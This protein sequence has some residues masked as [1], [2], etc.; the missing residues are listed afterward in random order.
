MTIQRA[1]LLLAQNG[2][3][4]ALAILFAGFA[5]ANP[6]F[7]SL[8]NVSNILGQSVELAL[9]A[10]P[11][12]LLVISGSID[13]SVG[14][15]A[16]LAAVSAALCM[17]AT[18]S[19]W[20]GLTAGL[21]VGAAA[22]L[23]NGVLVAY[24]GFNSFVV[25]L[26]FLSIWGGLALLLSGGRGI[27]GRDLPGEFAAL[28]SARIGPF[29]LTLLILVVAVALAWWV[30]D[31]TAFGKQVFATGGN[32]R[33]AILMGVPVQRVQCLLFVATGF[34]AA[35]AGILLSAKVQSASPTV[36]TGLELDALTVVLLGGVAIAGGIGRISGVIGGVLFLRVLRNGLAFLQAPPFLQTV[37]IGA[38]LVIAVALDSTVQ[39]V[40]R[41]SWSRMRTPK[42]PS[43]TAST[44]S[45]T[46]SGATS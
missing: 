19:F 36:G 40:V 42:S 3:F 34:G 15:I 39:K 6:N 4:I 25:T 28:A 18:G 41:S 17:Q 11:L 22:G 26:G 31:H 5:L 32:R 45:G 30:L 9:V 14:S 12:A 37:L 8:S 16:S 29:P 35:L 27:S 23:V 1:K 44:G 38:T 13:F 7:A 43:P 33:A 2:I 10:L 21:L 46:T 24:L 20:L